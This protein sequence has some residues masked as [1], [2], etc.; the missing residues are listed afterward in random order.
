MKPYMKRVKEEYKEIDIRVGKL[1]EFLGSK[2]YVLLNKMD[3]YLL[4]SQLF[5]MR[6]Y[7]SILAARIENYIES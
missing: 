2:D 3:A 6:S 1:Q 5:I 4:D 7:R